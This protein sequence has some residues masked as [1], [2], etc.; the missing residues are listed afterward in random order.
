MTVYADLGFCWVLVFI[1]SIIK[2]LSVVT[3]N[4]ASVEIPFNDLK[5]A[6]EL[7]DSLFCFFGCLLCCF[8]ALIF[9]Q[10]WSLDSSL[11]RTRTHFSLRVFHERDDMQIILMTSD[12]V[13]TLNQSHTVITT[14]IA[15][16]G[17]ETNAFFTVYVWFAEIKA[18][19]T[20]TFDCALMR[21][22]GLKDVFPVC[23][24][25]N[26]FWFCCITA[27]KVRLYPKKGI[28]NS[29][30]YSP[31]LFFSDGDGTSATRGSCERT[32]V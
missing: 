9:L 6:I 3:L 11:L 24:H 21:V 2:L 17:Y 29:N 1:F 14:P 4:Q 10:T 5:S 13:A 8:I 25:L 12:T 16:W 28:W 32:P 18:I 30:Y 27:L 15:F 31:F 7:S 22:P 26:W 19:L 23:F 20:N